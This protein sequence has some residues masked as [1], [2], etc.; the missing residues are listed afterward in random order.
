MLGRACGDSKLWS[1]KYTI[2]IITGSI[3]L[4]TN[5]NRLSWKMQLISLLV[6]LVA[7]GIT[8][9]V[10]Y[11]KN[12]DPPSNPTSDNFDG[13]SILIFLAVGLPAYFIPSRILGKLLPK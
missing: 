1:L 12:F 5:K 11:F 7:M 9:K 13:E 3:F 8:E 2:G 6:S 4:L 10:E